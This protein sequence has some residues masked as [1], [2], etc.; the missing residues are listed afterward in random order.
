MAESIEGDKKIK[1]QR[2]RQGK[3]NK[4]CIAFLTVTEFNAYFLHYTGNLHVF[5]TRD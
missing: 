5:Y 4:I 3:E 2:I 1:T